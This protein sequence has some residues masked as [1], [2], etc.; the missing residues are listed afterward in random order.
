MKEQILYKYQDWTNEYHRKS[1]RNGQVYFA[2]NFRFN[3]IYDMNC[4]FKYKGIFKY[5]DEDITEELLPI[6]KRTPLQKEIIETRRQIIKMQKDTYPNKFFTAHMTETLKKNVSQT[7]VFCLSKTPKSTLMWGHY[8]NSHKGYCLGFNS[9]KLKEYLDKKFK[10]KLS[11]LPV[12]YV[13][14]FPIFDINGITIED[15]KISYSKEYLSYKFIQWEYEKEVRILISDFV[16]QSLTL[17]PTILTEL[18]FG[19]KIEIEH[20]DEI[21]R[22]YKSKYPHIKVFNSIMS[23]KTFEMEMSPV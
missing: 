8:A 17:D 16:N 14:D 10:M 7:G 19:N 13:H 15:F 2:N 6:I 23:K 18:I 1:F 12:T 11:I 5:T 21:S 4:P 20:K 3:D 9:L 22:L